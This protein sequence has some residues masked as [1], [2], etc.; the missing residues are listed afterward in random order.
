MTP[1]ETKKTMDNY[2]RELEQAVKSSVK[3]GLPSD[4]VG[5]KIYGDGTSIMT[6]GA[7][8]EY[9]TEN[10]PARSFLRMPFDLKR[11]EI[12]GYIGTQFKAVLTGARTA[13]DA[14]ERIGVKA[15]SISRA[16]FRN[17]GY[18]QW[19]DL[20]DS[21]KDAKEKAGKTTPLVWSGVLRN[22]ITWSID[23]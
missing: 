5:D 17:N 8:H 12:D 10:M 1:E 4:K 11:K 9:G 16:A 15:V 18:G 19:A 6:I 22:A 23:K 14:L 13:D 2:L 3:V 7:G 21:T 20:A